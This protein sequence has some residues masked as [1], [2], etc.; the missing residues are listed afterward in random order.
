VLLCLLKR[1]FIF[2]WGRRFV[3]AAIFYALGLML[4]VVGIIIIVLA[5]I[6]VS[7]LGAGRGKVKSAGVIMLGPIPIIF[8]TDKKSV[9][10]VLALSVALTIAVII[11]IVTYYWLLR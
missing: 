4:V 6:L 11:A 8:G 9:E 1:N 3:D 2:T 10:V 5:I 7:T